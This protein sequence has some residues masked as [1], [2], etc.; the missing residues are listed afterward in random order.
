MIK[1]CPRKYCRGALWYDDRDQGSYRCT[2][3]GRTYQQAIADDADD[4][5]SPQKPTQK[6]SCPDCGLVPYTRIDHYARWLAKHRLYC[7]ATRGVV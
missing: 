6:L 7:P 3:C 2:L 5:P 1:P 4:K